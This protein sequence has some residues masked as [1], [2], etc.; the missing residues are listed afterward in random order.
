MAASRSVSAG[1]EPPALTNPPGS[2]HSPANGGPA[3]RTS[4]TCRP[5]SLIVSVTTSTVTAIGSYSRGS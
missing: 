5:P 2:A 4:S 3:R 1:R